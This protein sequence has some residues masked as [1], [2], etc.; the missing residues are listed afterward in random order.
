MRAGTNPRTTL[1]R[2]VQFG[3]ALILSFSTQAQN[4]VNE[5]TRPKPQLKADD[6]L[7]DLNGAFR[8]TYAELRQETLKAIGP[9]VIHAGDT[10]ILMQNGIRSEAPALTHR[11]HELKSVAHV[12]LT[13]YAM[14]V[15]KT[16][17]RME[18]PQLNSIR[19]YR[20]MVAKGRESMI[21]R[22]FRSDQLDRQ[23]R[24]F[25]RS[26]AVIDSTLKKGMITKAELRRFVEAQ[27]A[28][29][30]ANA[31]EAAED[32]IDTTHRQFQKWQAQMTADE[33]SRIRVAVS[34][35][36]MPRVGNLAMQ[37]FAVVLKE[38]YEG[39]FEEEETRHSDFRLCFTEGVFD[40]QEILNS[41]GTHVVDA[42][43]GDWF[44]EDRQRMHRDLLADATEEIIRKRF[45]QTPS[46]R[47]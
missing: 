31:Y 30:L 40:E 11:Y 47:P 39:R 42:A 13:I 2:L 27:Q 15:G 16:E 43:I 8:S 46:T 9:V 20:H 24:L 14:L 45:G 18:E 23:L 22:G 33:R 37:Y 5:P 21:G 10:M 41:I 29:I 38:P 25:D 1:T 4:L 28:D 36:H 35:V 6:P 12:P 26:L 17:A 32:Q 7:A 44:F 34:S 19:A 3:I